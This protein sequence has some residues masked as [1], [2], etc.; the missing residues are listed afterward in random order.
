MN[1]SYDAVLALYGVEATRT[2]PRSLH[3]N[4]VVEQRHHRL[5]KGMDQALILRGSRDFE[6]EE[7]YR[8]FVRRIVDR[9]NRLVI[10]RLKRE[11][12]HLQSLPPLPVPEHVNYWVRMRR[13]STLRVSNRT[14]PVPSRLMCM[15]VDVR[16]HADHI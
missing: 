12:R 7:E 9:R 11:R 14:Y 10:S 2:G 4:G 16:L 6:S 3:E 8:T 13:W 5:R 1:A 15:V